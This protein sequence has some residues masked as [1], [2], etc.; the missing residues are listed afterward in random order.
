MKILYILK[1]GSTLPE[2]GKSYGDFDLWIRQT[3]G[4]TEVKTAVV[5]VEHGASL[6]DVDSCAGVI[7]SGSP[8][9]V[10]EETPA[11]SAVERWLPSLIEAEIPLL[12]ICFGHQLLARAMGGTVGF[13]PSGLEIGT[14]EIHLTAAGAD[15]AL[16]GSLPSRFPA[17]V[18]HAQSVLTLPPGAVVL[19]E[20]AHEPHHAFRLGSCAWGVQFH[21]EF[22]AAIL[23]AYIEQRKNE[24]ASAGYD[25]PSLLSEVTETP[26]AASV[27]QAFV[28]YV[29]GKNHREGP[30]SH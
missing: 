7:L 18:T 15:D 1:L 12:G 11:N 30:F 23:R 29:E 2:I 13:H 16:F 14:V 5:D 22:N 28:R 21:P 3:L 4:P 20:N 19:A 24:L 6:P 27:L 25:V 10:T 9:M 26:V 8:A 17:Q